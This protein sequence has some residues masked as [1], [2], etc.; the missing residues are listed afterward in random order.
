MTYKIKYFFWGQFT[1]LYEFAGCSTYKIDGSSGSTKPFC[2]ANLPCLT[3]SI[4][5][6]SGWRRL[7]FLISSRQQ[8]KHFRNVWQPPD[9]N[10]NLNSIFPGRRLYRGL[11]LPEKKKK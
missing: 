3:F 9:V 5:R 4:N 10:H 2:P 1:L 7:F 8:Q 11:S 6:G